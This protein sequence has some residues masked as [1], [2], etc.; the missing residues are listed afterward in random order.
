MKYTKEELERM[1]KATA[2]HIRK[3]NELI[4]KIN[5]K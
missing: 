3:V 5:N 1:R 4:N 2:E